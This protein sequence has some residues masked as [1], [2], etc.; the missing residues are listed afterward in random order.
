MTT[1]VTAAAAPR[2]KWNTPTFLAGEWLESTRIFNCFI[3]KIYRVINNDNVT[4][5][6]ASLQIFSS[7]KGPVRMRNRHSAA[8]FNSR[9]D[10]QRRACPGLLKLLSS[11]GNRELVPVRA[12]RFM[13]IFECGLCYGFNSSLFSNLTFHMHC[14]LPDV[15]SVSFPSAPQSAQTEII[16]ILSASFWRLI[17]F[18]NIWIGKRTS[19]NCSVI[20]KQS[21]FW[22]ELQ[23]SRIANT[24]TDPRKYKATQESCAAGK[25]FDDPHNLR[26]L[27]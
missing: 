5:I 1:T 17:N 3:M 8:A 20:T 10:C 9:T 22:G 14:H 18:I 16:Q 13:S 25:S 11:T 15:Q 21:Q 27:H 12:S 23:S 24:K 4:I 26:C 2:M 6:D 7:G 19:P